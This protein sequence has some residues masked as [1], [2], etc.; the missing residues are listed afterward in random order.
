MLLSS[1]ISSK[2]ISNLG[3]G[4]LTSSGKFLVL[5]LKPLVGD[6]FSV[7]KVLLVT[8]S[9]Y[10]LLKVFGRKGVVLTSSRAL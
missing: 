1:L 9:K 10:M 2:S 4:V 3:E 5:L 6:R 7:A 8:F